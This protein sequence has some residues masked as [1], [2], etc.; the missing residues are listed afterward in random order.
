MDNKKTII[1]TGAN[2]GLGFECARNI[3]GSSPE[4]RVVLACRNMAKAEQAKAEIIDSSGN[5]DVHAMELDVSSLA[6]VRSFVKRYSEDGPSPLY[7]LV[8]NAGIMGAN[9]GMTPEG[10][11]C[12]FATNHLGHFLLTNLLLPYMQPTGRV[13]NVSSDMHNPPGPKLDWPGAEA[14]AHPDKKR[15]GDRRRYSYSKLC[16][17]YFTYEL[18]TR[19]KRIHSTITVNAF[20]PGLMTDTNFAPDKSRFTPV[21]LKMVSDRVGSLVNSGAALAELM[22]EPQYGQVSGKYYDR[23]T[24]EQQSSPLSYDKENAL[25]LWNMSAGYTRLKQD[26]TLPDLL[27]DF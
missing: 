24:E 26:E 20:N 6:S 9:V 22:T 17:L 2:S 12:V 7:G 27:L 4:H 25:E 10:F 8:C 23:S 13:I 11:D 3:A 5:S 18:C 19:L 1:I 16:N 21:F 15:S 14:L